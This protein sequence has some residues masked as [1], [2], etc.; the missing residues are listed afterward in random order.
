[1]ILGALNYINVMCTRTPS[2]RKT[3]VAGNNNLIN[4]FGC[5][6]SSQRVTSKTMPSKEAGCEKLGVLAL[7]SRK[8][9]VGG[10]RSDDRAEAEA[11]TPGGLSPP[12]SHAVLKLTLNEQTRTSIYSQRPPLTSLQELLARP[13]QQRLALS[14]GLHQPEV[15]GTTSKTKC[16]LQV[17]R[18]SPRSSSSLSPPER[19][20]MS[21]GDGWEK[22]QGDLRPLVLLCLSNFF[23]AKELQTGDTEPCYYKAQKGTK[24]YFL[25]V[26]IYL[27]HTKNG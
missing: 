14:E 11:A 20:L 12:F 16:V 10:Q 18:S 1:M 23:P 8:R 26:T 6:T 19:R 13:D 21:Q 17:A 27:L 9:S 22:G 5:S 25:D 3:C 24:Y 4:C 15:L 2:R 7:Q